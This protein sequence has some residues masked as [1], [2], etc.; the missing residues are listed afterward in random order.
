LPT[1]INKLQRYPEMNLARMQDIG[2]VRAIVD[3]VT[4]VRK[5]QTQYQD[6]RRFTHE[7]TREDDYISEPKSDGYRGV[8]LVYKYNNTLA[9]N[10]TAS[11]YKGLLLELQ[12]RTRLQHIWATAVETMGTFR[13]EAL[14]SRQGSKEW[15]EFFALTSAAFAHVEQ[16][17][18]PSQ[19]AS[20]TAKETFQ[21]V[22]RTENQLQVLEHI[23]G[24]AIAANAIHTQGAGGFYN[25]IILNP[26]THSVQVKSY[27]ADQL[28]QASND[29]AAAESEAAKG[30]PVEPVLVSA[31]R[32]KS[33]R[34]AYPNYFLDVREFVEKVEVLIQVSKE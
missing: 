25:L 14:K 23:R 22:A 31:G 26:V 6:T 17:P 4:E 1:I 30:S 9:R 8:H 16:A 20:L 3:S 29:Y 11:S 19:Y 33:L 10:S 32:L 21:E 7:L 27:R 12:L 5:L 18:L 13:G 24:I 2:G 34:Q 28:L 15:L